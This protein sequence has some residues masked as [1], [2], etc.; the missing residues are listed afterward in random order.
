MSSG[1]TTKNFKRALIL[2]KIIKILLS[3]FAQIFDIIIKYK[4]YQKL[5][6]YL[7]LAEIIKNHS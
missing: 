6:I 1:L 7:T 3:G 4:E 5:Q 2:M